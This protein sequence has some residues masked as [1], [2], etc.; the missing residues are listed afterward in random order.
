MWVRVYNM[1][2]GRL[3][4]NFKIDGLVCDQI[5]RVRQQYNLPYEPTARGHRYVR[6]ETPDYLMEVEL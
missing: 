2:T 4:R 6:Y 1:N 5:E 3:C